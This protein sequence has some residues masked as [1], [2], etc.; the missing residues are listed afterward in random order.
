M[1]SPERLSGRSLPILQNRT[2]IGERHLL[3]CGARVLG[4]IVKVHEN[5]GADRNVAE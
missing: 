5:M 3:R 2:G 1:K 4:F